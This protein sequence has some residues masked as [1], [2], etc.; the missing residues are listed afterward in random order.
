MQ[1]KE[2][3]AL[4]YAGAG[5]TADSDPQKEWAETELKCHTLLDALR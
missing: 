4:L 3:K 5:I 1:Y 2:Q